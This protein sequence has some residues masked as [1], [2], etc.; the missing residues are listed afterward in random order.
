MHYYAPLHAFLAL[1]ACGNWNLL[2]PAYLYI[3]QNLWLSKMWQ[4]F[5]R[6][7]LAREVNVVV[8]GAEALATSANLH[9][10]KCIFRA[11]LEENENPAL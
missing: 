1:L 7:F 9:T 4:S 6:N 8:N 2:Y 5:S 10:A 3:A 11:A